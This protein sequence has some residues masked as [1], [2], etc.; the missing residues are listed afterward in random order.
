L[1]SSGT[2][3]KT[4]VALL[5]IAEIDAVRV[6]PGATLKSH[7]GAFLFWVKVALARFCGRGASGVIE[8]AGLVKVAVALM[9]SGEVKACR[10]LKHALYQP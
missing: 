9:R 1:L 5:L 10:T 8:R 7:T 4:D 6:S 2:D 3:T